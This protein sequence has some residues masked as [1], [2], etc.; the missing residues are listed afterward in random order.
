MKQ[1]R[2]MTFSELVKARAEI[3]AA[4][5][6]HI[7]RERQ[8]L[9]KALERIG[10]NTNG[11]SS[12]RDGRVHPLKGKKLRPK[13]RNPDDRSETWAGRGNRPRWLTAALKRG[14]KLESFAVK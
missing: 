7:A 5:E 9:T 11:P 1:I 6:L 13:Y 4:I 3:E 14:R 10:N 2:S 12:A 8:V